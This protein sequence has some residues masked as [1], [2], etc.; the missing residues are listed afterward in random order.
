M[1]N[2]SC[3]IVDDEPLARKGIELHTKELDWLEV[4]GQFQ[5]AIQA[6][7]FL[8]T[9]KID[10]IFLDIEMPGIN[11]IEYIKSLKDSPLIILTTAYPQFALEAFELD[12]VDYLLKPIRFERF[13][14]AVNKCKEILSLQKKDK[15]EIENIA[16]DHFYIKADR[17]YVK[18]YFKNVQYVKGMKDYVMIFTDTE[19]Y[20]TALNIK[21]IFAQLPKAIFARVSKS[22]LINT[23]RIDAIDID[24]IMIGK[25]EIPLGNS[26]KD[27]FLK[28]HVKGKLFKR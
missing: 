16:E 17:K 14:K 23:D 24:S 4:K 25:E 10:L 20:M 28:Q 18:L 22:Y 2:I 21:T 8:S 1:S 6:N 13:F 12:V 5:N 19:K 15:T 26:Y 9:N 7:E 3:I 11:G 27:D